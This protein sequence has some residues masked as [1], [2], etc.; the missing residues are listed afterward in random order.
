[1]LF[2]RIIFT[3]AEFLLFVVRVKSSDA[4]VVVSFAVLF[5]TD[6]YWR[7]LEDGRCIGQRFKRAIAAEQT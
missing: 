5:Y 4:T 3:R 2:H 1:M 6:L 7:N